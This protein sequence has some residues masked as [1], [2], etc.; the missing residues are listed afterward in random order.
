VKFTI[1]CLCSSD[2][3]RCNRYRHMDQNIANLYSYDT[4]GKHKIS[5]TGTYCIP[6]PTVAS[7]SRS[8]EYLCRV[9]YM[10]GT[11][12]TC[13][14]KKMQV[15]MQSFCQIMT[16]SWAASS[17]RST[18]LPY[19][20]FQISITCGNNV[21]FVL[22]YKMHGLEQMNQILKTQGNINK[23]YHGSYCED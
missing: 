16:K 15:N 22:S 3:W 8:I 6:P 2:S 7:G 20:P 19:P 5:N 13:E 17:K 18:Y 23:N 21:A 10:I 1:S 9:I 14:I 11:P 12:G 4:E